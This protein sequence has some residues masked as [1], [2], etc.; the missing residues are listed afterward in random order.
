MLIH[1]PT[2]IAVLLLVCAHISS[3]NAETTTTQPGVSTSIIN[4]QITTHESAPVQPGQEQS[5]TERN[6]LN[7]NH[8]LLVYDLLIN[9]NTDNDA[10]GYFANFSI[11]L[12]IDNRFSPRDVYAVFYLS[13]GNGPRFDFAVTSNFTVSGT[14]A[15]DSI[16]IDTILESGY[17]TDFYDLSA[18]VYDAVTGDLL[19]A[20]GPN[21][22]SHV[23][24]IPFE[25]VQQDRFQSFTSLQLSISGSG[26]FSI[27]TLLLFA[28][29]IFYRTV[30]SR[31]HR[32][33]N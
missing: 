22:S 5:S 20:Y 16:R 14:T 9:L 23:I 33:V 6:I 30:K 13:R 27:V 11:T 2:K 15:N 1:W 29:L 10:D 18:E 21:D 4:G 19:I 28:L 26:S 8:G 7:F 25:S 32:A 3:A 24:A 12:D 31:A 17:P